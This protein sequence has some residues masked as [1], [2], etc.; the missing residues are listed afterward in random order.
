MKYLDRKGE[1]ISILKMLELKQDPDYPIVADDWVGEY[2]VIT[3]WVG[4]DNRTDKRRKLALFDTMVFSGSELV[5]TEIASDEE[6]AKK[7]HEGL[8]QALQD[9]AKDFAKIASRKKIKDALKELLTAKAELTTKHKVPY[10]MGQFVDKLND[11]KE[12][13]T[14]EPQGE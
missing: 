10:T 7:N 9:E 2:Q 3:L 6:E 1:Q 5:K 11:F 14:D 12:V 13:K 8:L 4:T